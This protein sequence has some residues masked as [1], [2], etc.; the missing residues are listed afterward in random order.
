M[1]KKEKPAEQAAPQGKGGKKRGMMGFILLMILFGAAVPFILP[2]LVLFIGML[3]TLV[4]LFTD[5]DRQKSGAVAVGVMNA[6]GITPFII[7]LWQKGQT[8]ENAFGILHDPNTWFVMLGAAG[9]GQLILFVIP[10]LI[11]TFTVARSESRLKLLKM[12]LERLKTSW[13]PDVA[14]TKP[15]EKVARGE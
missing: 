6:A 2:S 3:P 9:I 5:S 1:A 8:M 15:I 12:N 14:T 13:G 10:Q 11:A 4:A 7:E